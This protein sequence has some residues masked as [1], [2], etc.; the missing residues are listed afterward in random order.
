MTM[1]FKF[2]F[3]GKPEPWGQGIYDPSKVVLF[4]RGRFA[5]K[6]GVKLAEIENPSIAIEPLEGQELEALKSQFQLPDGWVP[7]ET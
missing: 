1:Y 4:N 2:A 6:Q 7:N 3:T 5:L